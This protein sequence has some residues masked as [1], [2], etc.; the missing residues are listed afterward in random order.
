MNNTGQATAADLEGL[1][2]AV[3]ADVAATTGIR[4]EWEIKRIGRLA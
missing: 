2:E 3:R 4:L 1:G